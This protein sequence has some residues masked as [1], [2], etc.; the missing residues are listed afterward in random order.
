[1]VNLLSISILVILPR[2]NT[3]TNDKLYT[4][5]EV[6]TNAGGNSPASTSNVV[7]PFIKPDPPT[8]VIADVSGFSGKANV[9]WTAPFNGVLDISSY[10]VT[11]SPV[12][13]IATINFAARSALVTGLTNGSNYTFTVVATN[14]G[15]SSTVSAPSN[16]V[17]PFTKPDPPTNV[18]AV[19]GFSDKANIRWTAPFNG[20]SDIYSYTVTSSP[21]GGIA[22]IN[23]A[24]RSALVTGLTNGSNYTFTVVA[25]NA[26]GSSAVSAP[27]NSIRPFTKP[28]PPTNVIADVSGFSGEANV[29]WTA[30]FNGDLDIS[31]YTVTSSPVGGIATINFVARSALVTGLRNRS[32]YTFTVVATNAGGSSVASAPSN[33]IIPFIKLYPPTN[34][35]ADVSGFNRHANVRW[36]V[37]TNNGLKIIGYHVTSNPNTTPVIVRSLTITGSTPTIVT[38]SIPTTTSFNTLTNG[39]PYTF[40][41]ITMYEFNSSSEPSSPSNS[42]TPTSG[43]NPPMLG[44]APNP[45]TNVT[46]TPGDSFITINWTAPINSIITDYYIRKDITNYYIRND[47]DY[48]D[49]DI[50]SGEMGGY[51]FSG[52][53]TSAK[54]YGLNKNQH[55]AFTVEARNDYGSSQSITIIAGQLIT[56]R[57]ETTYAINDGTTDAI[58][59]GTTDAIKDGTS[60]V[61]KEG[62]S[63]VMKYES[64]DNNYMELKW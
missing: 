13:G 1:M 29:R 20:G 33:S 43:P 23:F 7:K 62:M 39:Q 9:R 63:D 64:A 35:I 36:T 61:I 25:T 26:G 60:D 34:V 31:S 55:Y 14:A 42:V 38:T 49:I 37:P 53:E 47:S 8:N 4:L 10:T 59:D 18:I 58:N 2:D 19:C 45:P 48:E 22:T 46:V 54:I 5:S 15:G 12:G 51:S 16:V 40:T 17:K 3:I 32:N 28:D 6:A 21:V 56:N 27:S 50:I 52:S 30:P 11:S 41:V 44:T 57:N 24:A